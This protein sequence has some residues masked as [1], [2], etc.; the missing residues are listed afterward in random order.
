MYLGTD[1]QQPSDGGV[2]GNNSK[3]GDHGNENP[4]REGGGGSQDMPQAPSSS[5][6]ASS[7]GGDKG[8][9]D[10]N[11]KPPTHKTQEPTEVESKEETND[12]DSQSQSK[13]KGHMVTN[14][15]QPFA[16]TQEID[17]TN[18]E[19]RSSVI[20][21]QLCSNSWMP[22][23][24]KN[25]EYS[26]QSR[27]CPLEERL[28]IHESTNDEQQLPPSAAS[29]GEEQLNLEYSSVTSSAGILDQVIHTY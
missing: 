18:R 11:K 16:R 20:P 5:G 2:G 13:R 14:R 8:D 24:Y 23:S 15:L 21:E 7:S 6:G 12:D 25:F 10:P 17:D 28:A 9:D 4:D 19:Q 27:M 26:G 3:S 22:P 1:Q 29:I